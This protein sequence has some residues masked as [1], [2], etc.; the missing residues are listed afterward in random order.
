MPNLKNV[1]DTLKELK[2]LEKACIEFRNT[3]AVTEPISD[4]LQNLKNFMDKSRESIV[5][6][7]SEQN[8]IGEYCRIYIEELHVAFDPQQKN[9]TSINEVYDIIDHE[10]RV[11]LN[12]AMARFQ[13]ELNSARD[14][15]LLFSFKKTVTTSKRVSFDDS[16]AETQKSLLTPFKM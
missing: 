15:R 2:N 7:M 5:C 6:L 4:Q 14:P 3:L 8:D 11:E 10:L 9:V 12:A 1:E 13:T 16:Q